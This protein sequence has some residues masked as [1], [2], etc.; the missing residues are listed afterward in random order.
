MTRPLRVS[1]IAF[2][3][4]LLGACGRVTEPDSDA[5]LV[6]G[7]TMADASSPS[8]AA[9]IPSDAAVDDASTPAAC[10][11]VWTVA[12]ANA[13]ATARIEDGA[14][15]L[16][17]PGGDSSGTCDP[18]G[19]CYPIAAFQD[20]LVGD[21]DA[22]VRFEAFST[23]GPFSRVGLF[24]ASGADRDSVALASMQYVSATANNLSVTLPMENRA[25]WSNATSGTLTIE[26]RA[27]HITVYASDGPHATQLEGAFGD[28]PLRIGVMV[29]SESSSIPTSVR[30]TEFTVLAADHTVR[31]DSFDCDSLR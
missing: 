16:S 21:F 11:S 13:S 19:P 29:E 22:H 24:V 9:P 4:F 30:V 12:G 10:P 3:F 23:N 20:G 28:A 8:D 18:N 7:A 15:V 2:A 17:D 1:R 14:L 26:R 31:S 5:A 6:D 25:T 27:G